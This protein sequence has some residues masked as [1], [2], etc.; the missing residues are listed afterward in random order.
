M[1]SRAKAIAVSSRSNAKSSD[2]DKVLSM[3]RKVI[4]NQSQILQTMQ[5]NFNDSTSK[6]EDLS[7]VVDQLAAGVNTLSNDVYELPGRHKRPRSSSVGASSKT[8]RAKEPVAKLHVF[9]AAA[10]VISDEGNY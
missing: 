3:L 1:A 8:K 4:E 2:S 10:I 6:Q 7:K 5:G 9:K